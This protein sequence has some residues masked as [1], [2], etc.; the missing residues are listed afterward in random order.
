VLND[1]Q[2]REYLMQ[3]PEFFERNNDL[4]LS[5]EVGNPHS[6]R[7]VSIPERQLVATREKVRMLENKL[8]QLLTFGE[9]ND[10]LSEKIHKLTMRLV[11]SPTLDAAVDT[12]YLD[13]LD[14]FAVPHVAVRLWDVLPFSPTSITSAEHGA[15]EFSP[16]ADELKQFV[17]AMPKPYCGNHPV[18]ETHQ[19]FGEHAP[20]LKSYALVPMRQHPQSVAPTGRSFGV[21]LMASESAERFYSDMGTMFLSRIG[22]IFSASIMRELQFLPQ[23]DSVGD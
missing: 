23:P 8:A 20:H 13:L 15:R 22:D 18:Y 14:D 19:W 10:A 11:A 17:D 6:G 12:L 21:L 16:V 2:V 4:L 1:D 5:L 9:E 3:Q 7:T